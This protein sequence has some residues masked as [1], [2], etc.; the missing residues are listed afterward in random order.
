MN[1]ML[2]ISLRFFLFWVMQVLIFNQLEF[3]FG[4]HMMI[5]PLFIMLLPFD[6]GDFTLMFL[7][8]ALGLT[9]DA[10][11]DTFGLHA[12]SL[13]MMAGFRIILFKAFSQRE[14]YDPLKEPSL[15][16]MGPRWFVTVYGS[17]LLIHHFW[18]FLI[19]IFRINEL[20]WI[21]QNTFMSIIFSFS[22]SLLILTLISRKSRA[23]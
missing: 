10:F 8:F 20:M 23:K 21:L 22:V 19:E 3:G 12:S 11:S 13:L 4:I 6:I 14:A 9:I 2:N 17:L 18:F 15:F 7:G 5:Y 16:D 1:Y